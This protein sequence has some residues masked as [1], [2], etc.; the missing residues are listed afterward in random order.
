MNGF[1]FIALIVLV[2][3]IYKVAFAV[4]NAWA[5]SISREQGKRKGLEHRALMMRYEKNG[6]W[7]AK[8]DW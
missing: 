3:C 6:E 4:I 5:I 8:N 1:T 7:S 2:Y